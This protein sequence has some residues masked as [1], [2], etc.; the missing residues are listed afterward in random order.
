MSITEKLWYGTV[1]MNEKTIISGS[2]L[3]RLLKSANR[4]EEALSE[5]LTEKQKNDLENLL[6]KRVEISCLHEY[7]AFEKGFKLGMQLILESIR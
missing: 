4:L 1:A 7:E 6:S 5:T 2:E 3:D